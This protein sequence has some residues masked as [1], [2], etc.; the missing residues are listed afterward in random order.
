[1]LGYILGNYQA[2]HIRNFEWEANNF[3]DQVKKQRK[4]TAKVDV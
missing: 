3:Q 4:N 2:P 1:M